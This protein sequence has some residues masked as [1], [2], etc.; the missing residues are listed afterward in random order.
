MIFCAQKILFTLEKSFR[1]GKKHI[2]NHRMYSNMTALLA[3]LYKTFYTFR[4]V[5]GNIKL[6]ERCLGVTP[7]RE[8]Y[9]IYN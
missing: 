9:D 3:K 4:M 7:S 2:S 1:K 8:K 5:L 6:A